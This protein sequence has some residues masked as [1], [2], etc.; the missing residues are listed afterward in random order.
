MLLA[1]AACTPP[2][3]PGSDGGSAGQDGGDATAV[4]GHGHDAVSI[5]VDGQD[6]QDGVSI[7]IRIGDQRERG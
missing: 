3:E 1:L 7:D 6:G 2:A 5:G 4:G